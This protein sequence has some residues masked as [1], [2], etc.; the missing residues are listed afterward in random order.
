MQDIETL[1]EE[2]QQLR[3][4]IVELR[5]SIRTLDSSMA[6]LAG[7]GSDDLVGAIHALMEELKKQSE[8]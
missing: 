3:E 2:L 5:K 4:E 6:T 8:R 7:T 1:T